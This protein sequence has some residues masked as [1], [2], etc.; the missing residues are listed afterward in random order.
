[1]WVALGLAVVVVGSMGAATYVS[2]R[3]GEKWKDRSQEWQRRA[4]DLR[5]RLTSSEADAEALQN[6]LDGLANEKAQAQDERNAA[7]TERDL[8]GGLAVLATD[9]AVDVAACQRII[10]ETLSATFTQ[11]G[12]ENVAWSTLE[13]MVAQ[14]ER[15]CAVADQSYQQ[16]ADAVSTL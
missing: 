3:N 12:S 4:G 1:V 14:I 13:S 16:F 7:E 10:S 9:A 5:T 2:Y 15:T 8:Y 11:L 6:R